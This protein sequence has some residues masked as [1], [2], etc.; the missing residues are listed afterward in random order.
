ML[1]GSLNGAGA[2]HGAS[3]SCHALWCHVHESL[4]VDLCVLLG[5]VNLHAGSVHNHG[6]HQVRACS[7]KQHRMVVAHADARN[8]CEHIQELV[9]I[10]VRDVVTVGSF[11]INRE[12]L[13][14]VA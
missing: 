11:E 13:L 9:S 7:F 8:R 10:D 12:L 14:L 6:F 3:A 4:L 2:T 5:R 1:K